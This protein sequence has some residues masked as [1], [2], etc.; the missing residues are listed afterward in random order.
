MRGGLADVAL[1]RAKG[2][3]ERLAC[4]GAAIELDHQIARLCIWDL[5]QAHDE[6]ARGGDRGDTPVLACA[7]LDG[8]AFTDVRDLFVAD[9][10]NTDGGN[11][12]SRLAFARDGT[13][14]MCVGDR[15][16]PREL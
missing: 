2:L 12:G 15:A 10:W 8:N 16:S 13:I 11:T 3:R 4:R 1:R 9:A 6:R 5:P 7:R 14:Y